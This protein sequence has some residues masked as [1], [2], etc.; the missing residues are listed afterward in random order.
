M[1]AGL[2]SKRLSFR[3]VFAAASKRI[4]FVTIFIAA[5]ENLDGINEPKM[6]A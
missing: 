2:A 1:Q 3:K 4:L 6:A 5:L